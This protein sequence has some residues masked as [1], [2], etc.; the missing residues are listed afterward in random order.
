MKL[1]SII[2]FIAILFIQTI[3]ATSFNVGVLY[4]INKNGNSYIGAESICVV[5]G[6]L[7]EY[8]NPKLSI[9]YKVYDT[10]QNS[11][12]TMK[13]VMQMVK[14]KV[15]LVVGT[16]YSTTAIVAS[17]VL[18]K[19]NI[20]FIVPTATNPSVTKNSKS[21]IRACYDD[22][23]QGQKL[24]K[25]SIDKKRRNILVLKNLSRPFS[26]FLADEFLK[27]IHKSAPSVKTEVYELIDGDMNYQEIVEKI[28]K[29]QY[30][31]IFTTL[32]ASKSALL[33]KSIN[34]EKLTPMILGTD[35]IGGR[36][37]FFDILG[38]AHKGL[39]FF[40]AAQWDGKLRGPH[41]REFKTIFKKYCKGYDP[42]MMAVSAFDILKMALLTLD[43]LPKKRKLAL[44][45][46]IK[47]REY[48][49]LR[50]KLIF[51]NRNTPDA[52]IY[53]KKI[54]KDTVLSVKSL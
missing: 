45:N 3:N 37:S 33:Y 10:E 16:T 6:L 23:V 51:T 24:A 14:D 30:D 13:S 40:F 48:I 54:I 7:K 26:S 41:I 25:F 35:S 5:E 27:E 47:K 32:V 28:K 44:I 36:K 50:N 42:T 43:K 34:K 9:K 12:T 8:R 39:D 49:G 46:E 15:D 11:S 53:I 17:K 1:S 20:P 22:H 18:S 31:L 38:K 29:N 52:P 21:T 4:P 2:V 19:K